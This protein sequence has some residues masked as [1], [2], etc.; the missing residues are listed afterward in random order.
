MEEK[1]FLLAHSFQG[2]CPQL[3][4]PSVSMKSIIVAETIYFPIAGRRR[5]M[6][7]GEGQI[8]ETLVIYLLRF[9]VPTLQGF[10]NLPRQHLLAG[11]KNSKH[12]LSL[13]AESPLGSP[14]PTVPFS[15]APCCLSGPSAHLWALLFP[16]K[17]T[18][19]SNINL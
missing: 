19:L 10:Q 7:V 18:Q 13:K 12:E 4:A 2:I 5:E 11:L 17:S 14:P 15:K 1:R 16:S 8:Q 3:L 6:G 9:G